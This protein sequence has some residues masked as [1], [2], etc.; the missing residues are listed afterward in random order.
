[1]TLVEGHILARKGK[2][3]SKKVVAAYFT[4]KQL[5][6]FDFAD[7]RSI[8][9]D[10]SLGHAH[11]HVAPWFPW[12]YSSKHETLTLAFNAG[13]AS[14]TVGQHKASIWST[15][16]SFWDR[17]CGKWTNNNNTW[18]GVLQF[19]MVSQ[20]TRYVDQAL[21]WCRNGNILPTLDQAIQCILGCCWLNGW[22]C[23]GIYSEMIAILI[24]IAGNGS[25]EYTHTNTTHVPH[26]WM[27]E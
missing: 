8:L 19:K 9:A 27:N 11:D 12:W 24:I 15:S 23:V 4:S 7:T 21:V 13:S 17:Y 18:R 25:C 22:S 26:K 6:P 2:R 20:Q 3:Q 5:L 10:C 14:E 16:R 1:M